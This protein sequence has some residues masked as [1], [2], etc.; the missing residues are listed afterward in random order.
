METLHERIEAEGIGRQAIEL[1]RQLHRQPELSEREHATMAL[2]ADRL[3]ALGIPCVRNVADTGLVGLIQGGG[4]GPTVALRADIDALPI[5]EENPDLPYASQTPGVMHA[6]GHDIHTAVLWGTAA[7]L[8]GMRERLRGN[9]KLLF[10]PAEESIGGAAR[11]I[12]AGCLEDPAVDCVLGLH[13]DPSLPAGQIGIKYGKMYAASDMVTLK[14]YGRSCHGAH[15]SEGVDA[16]LI[17]AQILT[18]VQTVVSR[19]VRPTDAAVCSFGTIRGGNVRNQVADYV[20]LTGILR[21]LDPDTRLF[22]R[23]RVQT[24]CEQTAAMLGGRAEL[25][26]E[27]SYSPLINDD[28]LVDL[29]RDTAAGI[30]G[31]ENVI[32]EK[33]PSLGVEDFAYFAAARPACFF[34]LGCAD[35]D[36]ASR[37]LHS[38]HFRADE[39]CIPLG[40]ELQAANALRALE[41]FG[42]R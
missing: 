31:A 4:D 16:I 28:G 39:R 12:Q 20:E 38:C 8:A 36:P 6:C 15:P 9:V 42:G 26:V 10:Q 14:V 33:D 24:I 21:T 22:V 37:V 2:L 5:Q 11:M 13:V 18:A 41:R 35:T 17:A 1:R 29:V 7:V 23:Q 19:N 27:P 3:G 30:L 32:Q 25:V 40:I 34:H